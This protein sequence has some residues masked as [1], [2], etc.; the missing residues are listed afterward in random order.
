MIIFRTDTVVLGSVKQDGRWDMQITDEDRK[1]IWERYLKLHPAM[2][3]REILLIKLKI[4]RISGRESGERV[5]WI[6]T[7]QEAGSHRESREENET[8]ETV[9][10]RA[11]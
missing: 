11:Y 1:D 6:A 9:Y 4:S 3:A 2:K 10:G 5:V 7:S 8:A